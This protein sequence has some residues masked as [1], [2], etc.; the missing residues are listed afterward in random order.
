MELI[1]AG[2]TDRGRARAHN[3]DN[4]CLVPGHTMCLVADGM[5]GHNGGQVASQMAVDEI[6]QYF[7]DGCTEPANKGALM[8][9]AITRANDSIQ[10]TAGKH[11]DLKGMGTTVVG[12]LFTSDGVHVAHV[13]D[14]R[15]YRWRQGKL[16]QITEDHSLATAYV[17][18]GILKP[19][20][21]PHFAYRNVIT[22]AVGVAPE[23][24]V[25]LH[26]HLTEVGDV[27]LLCS[28]GLTDM[29]DDF[30][31]QELL[32]E[33]GEDLDLTCSLLVDAANDRGGADNITVVLARFDGST[34]LA[35]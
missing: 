25:E 14:A 29:V 22:R 35:E 5:G 18:Q 34:P 13:G 7:E 3:E 19:E 8:V 2:L 26:R 28:D 15:C 20:E 10:R 4:Y 9:A 24:E 17:K 6:E 30:V 16:E 32:E 11:E 23:V 21:V 33:G 31:I 12:C 1:L 27:Y